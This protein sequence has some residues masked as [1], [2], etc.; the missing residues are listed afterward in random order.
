YR[1]R[2]VHEVIASGAPASAAIG[3]LALEIAVV[4]GIGAGALAAARRGGLADRA[5]RAAADFLSAFPSFIVAVGLASVF[6]LW[7]R[8]VPLG[9]FDGPAHLVLPAIALAT[10]HAA[11]IARLSRA[12]LLET[13]E[14]DFVRTA[15]AKGVPEAAVVLRHALP[16]AL[17]PVVQYLGPAAAGVVT[18]SLGVEA[19]FNVPGLGA[20]FVS[21]ALNRD[22]TLVLGTVLLYSALL[23]AFNAAADVAAAWLDP[24]TV[25][26]RRA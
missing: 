11:A 12:S 22:Y 2:S 14:Q 8:L 9:R 13:L 23:L 25:E 10:S 17:A 3:L 26:A 5:V 18:G 19:V 4:A 6:C 15:R 21:A 7:L 24:R 20:H 16:P 1:G